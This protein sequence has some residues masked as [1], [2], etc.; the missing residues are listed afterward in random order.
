MVY[1]NEV[2]DWDHYQMKMKPMKKSHDQTTRASTTITTSVHNKHTSYKQYTRGGLLL[3]KP[4][5][6]SSCRSTRQVL[7]CA[8][9]ISACLALIPVEEET[10]RQRGQEVSSW[11]ACCNVIS[12]PWNLHAKLMMCKNIREDHYHC[13]ACG[14]ACAYG[15]TCCDGE[16]VDLNVDNSNCG[17]CGHRCMD[18]EYQC[19][20][21]MCHYALGYYDESILTP[22]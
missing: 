12:S 13:G 18:Y 5:D 6:T 15:L 11:L 20:Y 10:N 14:H 1:C 22:P 8:H 19:S 21:G 16:C 9:N 3:G 4:S 17:K 2:L 7:S